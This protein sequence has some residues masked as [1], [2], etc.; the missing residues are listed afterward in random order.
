MLSRIGSGPTWEWAEVGLH[1]GMPELHWR[2][3]GSPNVSVVLHEVARSLERRHVPLLDVEQHLVLFGHVQHEPPQ[4]GGH[5]TAA[6][7]RTDLKQ[8]RTQ[9][10]PRTSEATILARPAAPAAHRSSSPQRERTTDMKHGHVC[11]VEP[12]ERECWC[13][14]LLR[15]DFRRRTLSAMCTNCST[16]L[17]STLPL[18]P[19]VDHSNV[20]RTNVII[21][22]ARAPR[23]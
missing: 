21:A 14:L 18:M 2:N 12:T 13:G 3:P 22:T 11:V 19:T 4:Q 9:K 5:L 20:Q 17:L 1:A 6:L 23:A 7:R 15:L 8:N 16:A 10:L